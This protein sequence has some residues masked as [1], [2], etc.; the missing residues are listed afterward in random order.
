MKVKVGVSNRHIHL[1]MEDKNILF[2]DDYILREKRRL[3]QDN[4]YACF[5]T[6][7]L[8][9]G[10][11]KIENVRVIG[12][13]RTYT[14][15]EISKEDASVLGINPPYRNSGDLTNAEEIIIESEKSSIKRKCVIL[16]NRHIHMTKAISEEENF[17]NDD[18]VSVKLSDNTIIDNVHIKISIGDNPELHIDTVDS[19]EYKLFTG[20]NVEILR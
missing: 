14:Q 12:P 16:S 5:E 1:S 18:I 3:S 8:I 20:D 13:E 19:K 7:N 17:K 2:G 9:N 4:N 15:V 10:D 6:V 11:K